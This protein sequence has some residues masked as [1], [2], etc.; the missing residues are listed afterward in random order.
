M[1]GRMIGKKYIGTHLQKKTGRRHYGHVYFSDMSSVS[2]TLLINMFKILIKCNYIT[3]HS[4][5]QW[6]LLKTTYHEC[7][8]KNEEYRSFYVQVVLHSS[9]P[10][11]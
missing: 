9:G 6:P 7:H 10:L 11:A 4:T 1:E 8:L 2:K 5:K 3:A